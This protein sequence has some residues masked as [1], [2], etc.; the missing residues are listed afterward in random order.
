MNLGIKVF[1]FLFISNIIPLQSL[2]EVIIKFESF[3]ISK[4]VIVDLCP[5][6]NNISL[7][8]KFGISK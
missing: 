1:L 8:S 2:D 4:S 5:F 6:K 3:D 7:G